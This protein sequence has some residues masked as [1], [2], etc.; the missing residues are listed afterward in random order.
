MNNFHST[1]NCNLVSS[2]K[3]KTN[4][5]SFE[6]L[7]NFL[8]KYQVTNLSA[9]ILYLSQVWRDLSS[10]SPDKSKGI[11]RISFSHYYPLPGLISIRLFNIFDKNKDDYLSP[12]EFIEGMTVLFSESLEMLI[13]FIF[14]FYDFDNDGLIKKEDI[15]I[16]LEYVPVP[17][18]FNGMVRVENEL[19][20]MLK[21][22]FGD[23]STL[24]Y[25]SFYRS[26][27]V[28]ETFGLF[29]PIVIFLYEKNLLLLKLKIFI[30]T[31][32]LMRKKKNIV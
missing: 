10:R 29:I 12:Q 20:K 16:I 24:D 23:K 30:K 1:R 28:N 14:L 13:H 21:Q 6:I 27:L 22:A 8:S 18:D 26:I 9:F 25:N 31:S 15:K 32:Y 11:S 5:N 2:F 7:Q 4:K 3:S 17:S 19:Y